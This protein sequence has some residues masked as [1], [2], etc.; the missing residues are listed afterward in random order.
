MEIETIGPVPAR[1][2][3][4]SLLSGH[5]T[6]GLSEA[7]QDLIFPSVGTGEFDRFADQ[8][9]SA[10]YPAEVAQ[11]DS[12]R[13]LRTGRIST[14][15]AS[16]LTI[17]MVRFG[18]SAQVDPGYVDGYHVNVPLSGRVV[19]SF[20]RRT[21]TATPGMAAVFSFHGRTA[22][23]HWSS[24]AAQ[25]CIKI[26]RSLL[27]TEADRLLGRPLTVAPRFAMTMSLVSRQGQVWG[28]QLSSL[29]D[30]ID[31]GGLP[32]SILEQMERTLVGSLL[33]S[34]PNSLGEEL[35]SPERALLPGTLRTLLDAIDARADEVLVP[36]DLAEM[37]GVS[38]RR[39][40]QTFRQ[41]LGVSPAVY[42]RNERL[43]G[44]DRDLRAPGEHDTVTSVMHRWGFTNHARFAAL[45]R[46]RY[47]LKPS[48][49]L[50]RS[51]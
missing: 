15:T 29:I 28:R 2:R 32:R 14:R 26:P 9:N 27:E 20:A 35:A 12:A 7:E 44:A 16:R 22:L 40:E 46:D 31:A 25:L 3:W 45:Y 38:V 48:E 42:L 51:R 13:S 39:I 6:G 49:V 5:P 33:Y 1:P 30:A 8:L 10:Y 17:G 50:R 4:D 21:V 37:A 19:S 34:A 11:T 18:C 24:D 47:G 36:A 23:P 41:H 43:A